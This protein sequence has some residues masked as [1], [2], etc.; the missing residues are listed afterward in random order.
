MPI[1]SHTDK[2]K[3]YYMCLHIKGEIFLAIKI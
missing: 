1:L 2:E 3:T